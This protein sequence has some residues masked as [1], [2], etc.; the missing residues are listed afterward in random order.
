MEK[1]H[2]LAIVKKLRN[3]ENVK[4]PKC[5]SATVKAVGDYRTSHEYYCP[6]EKCDFKMRID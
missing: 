2:P 4:C 3:E 1:V 6:N 5:Q